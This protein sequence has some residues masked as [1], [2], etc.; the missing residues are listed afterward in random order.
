[1]KRIYLA[2]CFGL[3]VSSSFAQKL[4]DVQA[5][6]MPAPAN[7]KIDGKIAEWNDAFAAE[8]KRTEVCYTLAN[9]D[10]NLYLLLKSS[11]SG[12][13]GKIMAGGITFSVNTE[14]KKKEKDAQS[15]TYPVIKRATRGQGGGG[16]RQQGERVAGGQGGFQNRGQ[17]TA[18]QRDSMTLVQRKNQ[19]ATV[20]E[21]K[22]AGIKSIT[23]TLISIYNEYGIKIAASFDA[24]GNYVCEMAIP[25]SLLELSATDTKEFAYQIKI[26]GLSG[27]GFGGGG[28]EIAVRGGFGGNG[29]GGN[30]G[31]GGRP[32]GNFGGGNGG[33]A[34]DMMS[35]TDFW[36]KYSFVKK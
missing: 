20:K 33:N 10:K 17:Q 6:A 24:K 16:A 7:I 18:Q 5:S 31:G 11:S 21:I 2:L 19:L 12:N 34:T 32:G 26:N 27:M 22:V 15:I 23:D 35:A 3:L 9:D 30:F 1:M 28:G 29:G 8:N 25:L 36:G 13:T 14:G 4:P